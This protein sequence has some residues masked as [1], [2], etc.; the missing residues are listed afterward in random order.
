MALVKSRDTV[1]VHYTGKL[2]DGTIFDTSVDREPLEST[3]VDG[4]IIPL[5]EQ[6]LIGSAVIDK[7]INR[8]IAEE[9]NI[10]SEI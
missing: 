5:F 4:R 7:R 1:K 3:F 8:N 10:Q 2:N 6:A 9:S